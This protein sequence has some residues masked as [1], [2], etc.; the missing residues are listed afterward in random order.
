MLV[1]VLKNAFGLE[2][3]LC[4]MHETRIVIIRDAGASHLSRAPLPLV[5]ILNYE[6]FARMP[7]SVLG[8][9]SCHVMMCVVRTMRLM[10]SPSATR[11]AL[12]SFF[13]L[14]GRIMCFVV[15]RHKNVRL[16]L[17]VAVNVCASVYLRMSVRCIFT[18]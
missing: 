1:A 12:S 8:R 18:S 2:N 5:E 4:E 7:I 17:C 6:L 13:R 16:C 3:P 11:I 15:C 10:A 14:N 9:Q